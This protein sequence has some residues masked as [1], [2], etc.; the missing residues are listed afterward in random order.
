MQ[1]RD[2]ATACRRR[3][4]LILLALIATL[5]D[6]RAAVA[7]V[8]DLYVGAAAGQGRVDVGN[9][10][11]PSV[12]A[13]PPV[14]SFKENHSA[15]KAIAGVRLVSLFGIEVD[16]MDFGHP[17]TNVPTNPTIGGVSVVA[18]AKLSGS[19]AYG[20]LYLPVPIV[21][22]YVKGGVARLK[23]TATV[24]ATYGAPIATCVTA[25]PNCTFAQGYGATTTGL[26]AGL[27]AQ[28][29]LGHWALRAEYERF[30]AAG[31]NP[32]LATVGVTYNF[33]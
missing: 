23:E 21:D 13:V 22:V 17:N 20:V 28:F 19:A 29:K 26:A 4:A 7:D 15:F 30:N 33:L 12:I 2:R 27:G 25:A 6:A 11:N 9:L 18:D 24:T 8:L 14:A 10:S 3:H 31:G 16:Y 5:L 32:S 1:P